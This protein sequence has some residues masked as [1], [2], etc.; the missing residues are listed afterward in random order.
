MATTATRH[1]RDPWLRFPATW[2]TYLSLLRDRGERNR[3]RYTFIHGKLTVV[4]PGAS[5]ETLKER[6]GGIIDDLCIALDVPFLAFGSTTFL[7]SQKPRSG[8]EPDK[9]Y[10]LTRL[11]LVRG[12][13]QIV[14]G[15]D[16]PPDLVAEIV[17]THPLG[18]TLAVYRGFGVREVWVCRRSE[19]EFFVLGADGRYA[20]STAS[21]C[22]PF[23]TAEDLTHWA[24]RQ[25]LPD[26]KALR[27]QFR[28][29]VVET[30][31]GRARPPE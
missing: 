20:R 15:V 25:D 4:S 8:T 18:D 23:L 10:Y 14:M 3:P 1:V 11:D 26:D 5:H 24:Y 21:S 2:K 16:P 7:K 28:A 27:S 17:A 31:A 19:A 9:S 13:E 29:W 12:K 22:L 6:V 30:L